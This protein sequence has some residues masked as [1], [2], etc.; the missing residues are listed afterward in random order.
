MLIT[1]GACL[2]V[3]AWIV[4]IS[5]TKWIFLVYNPFFSFFVKSSR[6]SFVTPFAVTIQYNGSIHYL[7]HVIIQ[8]SLNVSITSIFGRQGDI[9]IELT[10]PSETQSV[11]LDYRHYPFFYEVGRVCSEWP[12]MSVMFWGEDPTGEW[13]LVVLSGSSYTVLEVY[14]VEFQFFGLYETPDSVANIPMECHPDCSRGCA[15][16][17]SNYC[18]AC[19]NLRNAYT[20]E[21][22]DTCPHGYTEQNG[23]CYNS[24]VPTKQC[25]STL[26]ETKNLGEEVT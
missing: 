13:N 5:I 10:S 12:F 16:E 25:N 11:L 9:R 14:D 23:Y 22:I 8:M 18:D 3:T 6:A 1:H 17:G 15:K 24:S 4:L 26:K 19:V 20:L 21:C 2:N 7:E